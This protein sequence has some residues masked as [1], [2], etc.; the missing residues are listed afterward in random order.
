MK[1][2][3]V[4]FT[5]DNEVYHLYAGEEKVLSMHFHPF[6]QSARVETATEKRVFQI[7][8]EGFLRNKTVLR[9]EYGI[10][11]G[12]LG[13]EAGKE[14]ISINEHRYF[15]SIEKKSGTALSIY[16]EGEETPLATCGLQTGNGEL[17][18]SNITNDKSQ[19]GLLM[20]FCWYL[21]LSVLHPL[22]A[23]LTY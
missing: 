11:I 19:T 8:K 7:R 23:E 6:S 20:T 17:H 15:F 13:H 12:E 22:E 14:F 4:S 5:A 10:K 16:K 21:F 9:S 18:I 3:K 1:W 2:E